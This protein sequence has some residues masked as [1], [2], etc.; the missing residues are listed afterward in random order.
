[1]NE[2]DLPL[3][4]ADP[5]LFRR[6]LDNLLENAEKYSQNESV[7]I[8]FRAL[9]Y[10]DRVAFE[11]RD[12]GIGIAAADLPHIFT[13]FFRA[14]R[15]RS[16]G[17]GGVGLGLSLVKRIV[18]AHGGQVAVQSD[19]GVGTTVTVMLPATSDSVSAAGR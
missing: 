10:L 9:R 17:A 13:P 18:E 14:E 6:V 5:I 3:V 8:E 11:V 1:M 12:R 19:V 16:R 7:P 15:S 2:N 4:N